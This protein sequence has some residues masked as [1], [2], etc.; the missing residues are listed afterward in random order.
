MNESSA[1]T[2]GGSAET[3]R[4][5]FGESSVERRA[6]TSSTALAAKAQAEVNARFIMAL[7]RPRDLDVVRDRLL[8]ECERPS[9]AE[10]AFFSVPRGNKA[11]RLTGLPGRIEGLS[12]RFAERAIALAGNF[13]QQTKSIYDDDFKRMLL[14]G[15]VDLETNAGYDRE[16]VIDKTIE[17]R[18]AKD[19]SV[20]L[21]DRT[22][23]SGQRVY[24]LQA[25]ED[26][27]LQKEGGLISKIFR[28][29]GL[30]LIPPDILEDCEVQII[31]TWKTKDAKDPEASRKRLLD[32]YAVLGVSPDELKEYIGHDGARLTPQERLEL[33]GLHSAIRENEITWAQALA[34]RRTQRA[35]GEGPTT[36]AG[37]KSVA[38]RIAE[39]NAKK[40]EGKP[41]ATA[42]GAGAKSTEK[43]PSH[44]LGADPAGLGPSGK[45]R[46]REPGEEG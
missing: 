4:Q 31:H 36:G 45:K 34:E 30:R 38:E 8:K 11:G 5:G 10:R 32:Q 25:T 33:G 7:Q 28:T 23:T 12:V 40:A 1:I 29:N 14:V 3:V 18:E 41:A 2:R 15:I 22:N 19:G 21:G 24:I 9:F 6:E 42:A 43:D 13:W 46:E 37:G 44:D 20:V 26:E 35:G 17:R 39:R 27:L 16:L